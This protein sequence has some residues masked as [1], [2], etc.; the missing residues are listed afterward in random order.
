MQFLFMLSS[1]IC[2]VTYGVIKIYAVQ[3]LQDWYLTHIILTH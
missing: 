2:I 1:V 3:I